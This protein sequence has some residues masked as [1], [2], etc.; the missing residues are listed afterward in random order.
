MLKID[1]PET[2]SGY[3]MIQPNKDKPP[4]NV[5]CNMKYKNGAG[6]TTFS[7]DSQKSTHVNGYED[8]GKYRKN[9]TYDLTMEQIVNVINASR[10]CEQFIK[11]YCKD[12]GLYPSSSS[13]L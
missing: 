13:G 3:H 12:A 4:F 8:K 5:F 10:Y 11:W 2:N 9:I 7:H 1:E 6:V